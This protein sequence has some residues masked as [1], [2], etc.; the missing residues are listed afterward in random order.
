M[1]FDDDDED[2]FN[3]FGGD[4]EDDD[5]W[6][7]RS[8]KKKQKK[9]KKSKKNGSSAKKSIDPFQ[10]KYAHLF[11]QQNKPKTEDRKTV[12]P[13]VSNLPGLGVPNSMQQS[14]YKPPKENIDRACEMKNEILEKVEA[15]GRILPPNTLDQLIDELGGP[16]N[17]AEMTG[18]KG[19]VVQDQVSGDVRYES[20]SEADI[21]LETLN[22]AEKD[23]FMNAEKDV[24]IISEAAP[25]GI[26]LQADR[27]VKNQKRRVH[28][29]LELPWSADRAIQQFGRTHRS[30]QVTAPEYI[31][32]ISD[33]AGEQ[34]FASIVAK[35]LE[36]LGA[37]TH[38]D[39][40]AGEARDLSRFNID[41]KYGRLALEATF[42]AIMGYE[43]PIVKPPA[44]YKGDFFKDI[45][46]GLVGVGLITNSEDMP[47]TLT[48]DKGHNDMSKF[49]NRILGM[50]V[51]KQNTLFKYFADT[52]N[53]IITQAKRTG[54]YDQ[55]I[56][57][58]GLTEEDQVDLVR[59]HTFIRKHST[60]KAKIELHV[61]QVER[62]LS[63]DAS[64]EK[65]Q[66]L[67]GEDEGYYLSQISRN[68]KRTAILA[69]QLERNSKYKALSEEAGSGSKDKKKKK[70][71]IYVIY[72][73]NTGQQVKQE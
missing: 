6:S 32:L 67:I 59:T 72:R 33:L 57:D 58:V 18:R 61:L 34:R 13:P 63:W 19:R 44:D 62:G 8:K 45:A 28:M 71:K 27:R 56:L 10:E 38:G 22:L 48:L 29:T 1:G 47:G 73:P 30:N 31:L 15:L 52:L 11:Q 51:E 60:G 12:M 49:L 69:V 26:S 70:D 21:P 66:E 53:A 16:E 43:T 4:S 24:A 40:R 14:T 35:R 55:G 37:L 5:P 20:R 9:S 23:R 65:W 17:V 2:D 64:K 41:N 7:K 68:G 50:H 39:R 25:S 3:P 42:K 46:D 54:K 36:S